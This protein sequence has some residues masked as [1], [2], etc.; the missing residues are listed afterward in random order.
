MAGFDRLPA[1]SR[2]MTLTV[3]L[4]TLGCKVNQYESSYFLETLKE[5]GYQVVSFRDRADI[6]LVHGCAVTSRAGFQTRQLLRRAQ[7]LNPEATIVS[8]GCQ[9]QLEPERIVEERLA[10]HIL[11]NISKFDLTS[12]LQVPGSRF[13]PV[14]AIA[15]PCQVN[16]F[17]PLVVSRMHSGRARAFLKVQDGCDACCSYCVVPTLRGRSRSLPVAEVRLQLD[18][19]LD[20]GYQEVVLTGIH[21]GQWGRDFAL[22]QDLNALLAALNH[23][24]MPSR[25]RLSSLEP[26]E[27]SAALIEHLAGKEWICP[28]FHVPLQSGDGD[29]LQQ[30]RRP[31]TPHQYTEVIRALYRHFPQAALGADVLAGFPGETEKQFSNTYQ[32]LDQLP[33]T[34]LHAFPFSPRPGT[35]AASMPHQVPSQELKR[36]VRLLHELSRQKK[37]AFQAGLLGQCV[38]VLAE[39][40]IEDGWWRGISENYLRVL[41]PAPG[42]LPQGFI[43][44][45]R[46]LEL[47]EKGL[48]GR[49]VT[50]P[51][52][53]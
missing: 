34:Y 24:P 6:Y 51:L 43:A 41:F 5:A 29:I 18:R 2:L 4:E 28:H 32:L 53:K 15:A 38:E 37:L 31:Y 40:Q 35:P 26:M 11:D 25:V 30:M 8:A 22:R 7:R 48:L 14:Q 20:H 1:E 17:R 9:A 16:A 21:L 33:L 49:P 23:G 39:A 52:Q 42:V 10:S 3:A 50:I 13:R 44:R 19:F 27:W 36:R 47:T 46:L 45:V 12:W